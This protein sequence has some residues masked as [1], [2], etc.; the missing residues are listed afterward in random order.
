MENNK[1]D[2]RKAE[3]KELDQDLLDKVAGGVEFVQRKYGCRYCEAVLENTAQ[4]NAHM[5][6]FHPDKH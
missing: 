5:K 1:M 2:N 6:E 3:T 4:L